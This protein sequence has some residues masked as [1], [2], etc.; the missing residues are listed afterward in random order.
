MGLLSKKGARA[1][2]PGEVG[3]RGSLRAGASPGFSGKGIEETGEASP[4]SGLLNSGGR[5]SVYGFVGVGDVAFTRVVAVEEF[6][7]VVE[8]VYVGE[9]ARSGE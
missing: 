4:E 6:V 5:F 9:Y 1:V 8:V 7:R 2:S 3:V